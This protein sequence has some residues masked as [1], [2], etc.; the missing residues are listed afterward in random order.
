[1][2][3][4]F[5]DGMEIIMNIRDI[6]AQEQ[7]AAGRNSSRTS[8]SVYAGQMAG[9][10][11]IAKLAKNGTVT[12]NMEVPVTPSAQK[13]G[14]VSENY[15]FPEV[16]AAAA[17]GLETNEKAEQNLTILTGEDYSRLEDQEGAL[18]KYQESSLER[19]VERIRS[20]REWKQERLEE[21]AE[22][23]A[24]LQEGLERVQATGFL[25]EKSEAQIRE[26]L[27]L[28]NLPVTQEL[29]YQVVSALQMSQS[30]AG[31]SD[32]AK[33]FL[34]A[35]ELPATIENIYHAE[36]S[37]M[38]GTAGDD[39]PDEVWEKYGPQVEQILEELG[40]AGAD[41]MDH[42]KW[43]FANEL[44]VNSK[45]LA[46]IQE[47][48]SVAEGVELDHTLNQIIENLAAGR[49]A[50]DTDLIQS[51]ITHQEYQDAA[52]LMERV[53]SLGDQDIHK[54]LSEIQNQ[55]SGQ[56]SGQASQQ[57]A[58]FELTIEQLLKANEDRDTTTVV[59][60]QDIDIQTITVRRQLE[61]IRLMMTVQSVVGLRRQGFDIETEPLEDVVEQ[62]RQIE[63]T[64]YTMQAQERGVVLSDHDLERMQEAVRQVSDIAQSPAAVLGA[65]LRQHQMLTVEELHGIAVSTVRQYEQYEQDFEAVGTQ[66]RQDLGDSIHKAFDGIPQMLQDLGLEDNQANERAVRIL[67]YNQMEIT[68]E[69]IQEMKQWDAEVQRLIKL[70]KPQ[71]V[72]ELI[73]EGQDP[74]N[75]PIEELNEQLSEKN[76]ERGAS[77]EERYARY[78]WQ[79]EKQGEIKEDERREYIGIYRLLH[80]IEKSDGAAIG[81]VLQAGQQMDLG[82]L[83]TA[84]RTIRAHGLDEKVSEE[85]GVREA[86]TRYYQNMAEEILQ[87]VTP[88][89]IQEITDGNPEQLMDRSLENVAEELQQASGEPELLQQYYEEQAEE[90]RE[91]V[92]QAGQARAYLEQ[93]EL[94]DTLENIRAAEFLLEEG[95]S[96]VK[97]LLERRRVLEDDEQQELDGLLDE[98]PEAIDT[99]ESLREKCIEAEKFM[100]EILTKSQESADI[101]SEDLKHLKLL[102]QSLR[103][104]QALT[105]RQSYEIPIRTGDTVT[106]MNL[107]ILHGGEETGK[108]R[109]SME[110]STFGRVSGEVQ[111]QGEQIKGLIL[112][113]DRV[114]FDALKEQG[115]TLTEQ[116]E[117]AGYS[118]KHISYGMD[119]KN[120]SEMAGTVSSDEQADTAKLYQIAK[121]L[122]RYVS[123]TAKQNMSR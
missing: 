53:G 102:G 92:R 117:S 80:Q 43:L 97:E 104:Q 68:T 15:S 47:L 89:K 23:R 119:Y 61:E 87:N 39:I 51:D 105:R 24:E 22:L 108:V 38:E 72:L 40:D 73:R 112:C 27:Q 85:E 113:D 75:I 59:S 21:N 100:Q 77:D 88:A 71:T 25:S 1:M 57:E 79:L 110:E 37:G 114:G 81:A 55:S 111:L 20:E 2:V 26:A 4:M 28:A 96:P 13:D 10:G 12:G 76:Q 106:T 109:I 7:T 58:P 118:V 30:A 121:I 42:A 63:N 66:V 60:E 91:T 48:E 49:R 69:S 122:V 33:H 17:Q 65:S 31:M 36:Y 46:W 34:M 70:M 95:A 14:E 44:P 54:A 120:R 78:L 99:P 62:L 84:I 56:D 41:Q 90:L 98:L 116:L 5:E 93:F 52:E 45:T 11:M 115:T 32:S 35:Q 67:G 8:A 82:H 74:L 19:A 18:E 3:S 83:R 6:A 86:P 103:L 9:E 29:I 64:Y 123:D 50:V 16:I 101:T 107:T 94:P